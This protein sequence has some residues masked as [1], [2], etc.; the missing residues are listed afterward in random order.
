MIL[1]GIQF[2]EQLKTEADGQSYIWAEARD[3]N[4]PSVWPWLRV[5][6]GDGAL[7]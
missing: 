4:Q 2:S 1:L 3:L 6:V 7:E 5:A